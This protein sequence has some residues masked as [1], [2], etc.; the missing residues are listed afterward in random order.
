MQMRVIGLEG[1]R[2]VRDQRQA[3]YALAD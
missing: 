3:G 1:G 2:L